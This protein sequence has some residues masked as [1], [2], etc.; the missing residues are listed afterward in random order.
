MPANQHEM[1]E[2]IT[3]HIR[4]SGGEPGE[5]WV[6]TAKD[7]RGAFFQRHRE[8]DLGDGLAY[9]EAY[10][11]SAADAVLEH[12]MNACGL[13]PD[14]AAAL[15]PGRLVFVY[16]PTPAAPAPP[17]SEPPTLAKLAA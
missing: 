8:R 15:E 2:E 5:W 10:T 4:K 17:A 14:P 3:A 6:G 7:A 16:H 1:I 11:T 13:R 9:R 12:L